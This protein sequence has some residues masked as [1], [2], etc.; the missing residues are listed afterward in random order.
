VA[1]LQEEQ[2]VDEYAYHLLEESRGGRLSRLELLQRA[3]IMGLSVPVLGQILAAAPAE[4]GPVNIRAATP[5]RGGT[6]TCGTTTPGTDPDPWFVVDSGGVVTSQM[7]CEYLTQPG[8]SNV[9]TPALAE[10]WAPGA[11]TKTWTFKIRQGV[12]FHDGTLMTADDVVATY[13]AITDPKGKSSALSAFAGV[14]SHGNTEKVDDYT[15]SFHLDRAFADFPYLVSTFTYSAVILPKTY[16]PGSFIKGGVGT[17][18]YVLNQYT[19]QQEA[20]Y[21]RNP[22]YWRAGLP[23]VDNMVVR[24][25]GEYPA[26]VLALQSGEVGFN[27]ETNYQGSQALFKDKNVQ[28]VANESSAYRAVALRV[29]EAPF[30]D[31]RVRQA[32]ALTLDRPALVSGLYNGYAEVGNDHAFAPVFPTSPST[33]QVPQRHRDIAQAKKL[34]TQAGHPNGLPVQITLEQFEDVPSYAVYIKQM[35][36]A[37]GIDVSLKILSAA[38]YY[39]SGTNQPWLVV[40]AG[41]T[42][43]AGR[44]TASQVIAP[45]YRAAGVWNSAHWKDPAFEKVMTKFDGESDLQKRKALAVKAAKIQH[46]AVPAIIAYWIKDLR[47]Q[48]TNVHGITPTP[49]PDLAKLWVSS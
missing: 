25:Y 10:S 49:R 22:N 44:G 40:P 45:A 29:D 23:Y 5:Q 31:V 26:I 47:S 28:V 24:Y 34:L 41:I 7:A 12:K 42:D 16:Q 6:L 2:P 43:W 17:G 32:L 18:P 1:R 48:R 46:D 15:V 19:A 36:K 27:L 14:L 38:A 39:G 21:T 3:A 4:A 8:K 35:A 33:R 30:K 37:A 20:Q 11:S 9:L 13:D